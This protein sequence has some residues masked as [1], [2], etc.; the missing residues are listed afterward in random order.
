MTEISYE[1]IESLIDAC[2]LTEKDMIQKIEITQAGVLCTL[3]FQ[4]EGKALTI[5]DGDT[6]SPL[7]YYRFFTI[8]RPEDSGE[9]THEDGT[10]HSHS[11]DELELVDSSTVA[12]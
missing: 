10:V 8:S 4:A 5:G 6:T 3:A 7:V 12:D 11:E 2:G 1:A 9:H